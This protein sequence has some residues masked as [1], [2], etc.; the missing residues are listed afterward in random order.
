LAFEGE[1]LTTRNKLVIAFIIMLFI[2][3]AYHAL[4]SIVFTFVSRTEA[5]KSS[6]FKLALDIE[7]QLIIS[8]VDF[9]TLVGLILLFSYQA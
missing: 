3:N 8:L 1:K 5:G 6:S 2:L 7:D 4:I 9:L